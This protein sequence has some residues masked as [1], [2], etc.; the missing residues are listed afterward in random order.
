M[1]GWA[2]AS[3]AVN[4]TLA[5]VSCLSAIHKEVFPCCFLVYGRRA[6]HG[7]PLE[8]ELLIKNDFPGSSL[9]RGEKC[10]QN[11]LILWEGSSSSIETAYK[12]KEEGKDMSGDG[13]EK[14]HEGVN[15][16]SVLCFC[17][18]GRDKE[19]RE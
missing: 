16:C 15:V 3:L 18:Q 4:S 17:D 7:V 2:L 9:V 1:I 12:I 8:E 5:T 6:C 13:Q 11:P 19:V 14:G 10:L